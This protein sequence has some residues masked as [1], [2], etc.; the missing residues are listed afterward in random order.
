MATPVN[1]DV[2]QLIRTDEKLSPTPAC[3]IIARND[4]GLSDHAHTPYWPAVGWTEI[5]A[6]SSEGPDGQM[7]T[8]QRGLVRC[9]VADSWEGGDESDRTAVPAKWFG[10]QTTCWRHNRRLVPTDTA[11]PPPTG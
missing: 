8:Y 7:V 9:E 6:F 2:T 5:W 10:Q 4:S 3:V 11:H 1:R